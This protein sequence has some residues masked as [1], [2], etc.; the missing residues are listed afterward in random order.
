M[1]IPSFWILPDAV[2]IHIIGHGKHESA[3]KVN[4]RTYI[5]SIGEVEQAIDDADT[6]IETR[7]EIQP[8]Y[9]FRIPGWWILQSQIS[10]YFWK[11]TISSKMFVLIPV[12]LFSEMP[13][14]FTVNAM[15]TR[16]L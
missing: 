15:P 7:K 1:I 14:G 4:D 5:E 11:D 6:G 9:I 2:L 8:Y 12:P 10:K 3:C 13:K 16:K